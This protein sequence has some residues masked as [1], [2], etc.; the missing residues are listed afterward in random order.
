MGE[1]KCKLVYVD[2]F[3]IAVRK[4]NELGITKDRL[5]GIFNNSSGD[6]FIIYYEE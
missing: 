1:S 5:V 6:L 3:T 4:I 2:N